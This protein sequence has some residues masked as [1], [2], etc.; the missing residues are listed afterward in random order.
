MLLKESKIRVLENFYALDY[1]F[2]GQP[3]S[4]VEA[5]CPLVKEE[6]LSIKGALL[7]VFL[8]MLKLMEHT[9]EG[10]AEKVTSQDIMVDAKYAAQLARNEAEQLVTADKSR[11]GIKAK[12]TEAINSDDEVDVTALVEQKIREKAFGLA[13]DNLLIGRTIYEAENLDDMDSWEGQIIEDSY[14]ILRDNLVEAAHQ[15]LY[16]DVDLMYEQ[17]DEEEAEG[18]EKEEA[19]EEEEDEGEEEEEKG[20][21]ESE[22]FFETLKQKIINEE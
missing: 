3:I 9:P 2:F 10:A 19:G 20:A 4:E 21:N 16:D 13:V 22:D 1:V 7:S 5:C 14:K 15:I 8:E 18:E 6:Y 17:D 12:I 11:D